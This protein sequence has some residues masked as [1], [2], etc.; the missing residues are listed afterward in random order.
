VLPDEDALFAAEPAPV[1]AATMAAA[2]RLGKLA[3]RLCAKQHD[4]V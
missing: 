2:D 1:L 3:T 4:S